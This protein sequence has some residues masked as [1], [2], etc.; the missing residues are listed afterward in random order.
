MHG[1]LLSTDAPVVKG[2]PTLFVF[3]LADTFGEVFKAASSQSKQPDAI[4]FEKE[5]V[6]GVALPAT[7]KPPKLSISR[8][9]VQD[10][11]LTVRYIRM[12]D[13]AVV[14]SPLATPI[15]PTLLIA[16]PKQTV[17]KTRLIENGKVMQTLKKDI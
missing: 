1:Y 14:K 6:I 16:I 3:E 13:S 17:L 7:N 5:M 4:N 8:V 9:F 11:T 15:Q 12:T 10:S 2:K